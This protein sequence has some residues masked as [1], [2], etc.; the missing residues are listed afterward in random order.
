MNKLCNVVCYSEKGSSR[1]IDLDLADS[2]LFIRD[3]IVF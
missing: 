3:A 2:S 1:E